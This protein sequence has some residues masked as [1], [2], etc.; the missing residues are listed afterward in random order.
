MPYPIELWLVHPREDACAAFRHR[1]HGLPHVRVLQTRFEALAPHDCFVE[2]CDW[3]DH[4]HSEEQAV[5]ELGPEAEKSKNGGCSNPSPHRDRALE[6]N[7]ER[8]VFSAARHT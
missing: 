2:G 5:S 8:A 7:C 6:A 3:D 1:F 4:C